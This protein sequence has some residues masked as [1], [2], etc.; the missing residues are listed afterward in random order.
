MV[1]RL[2]VGYHEH[3]FLMGGLPLGAQHEGEDTNPKQSKYPVYGAIGLKPI[4]DVPPCLPFG[5]V[6]KMAWQPFVQRRR[7][8]GRFAEVAHLRLQSYEAVQRYRPEETEGH[9]PEAVPI[10]PQ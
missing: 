7:G 3:S 2:G 1:Q 10:G 5:Q 6:I 8:M 4:L 9:S